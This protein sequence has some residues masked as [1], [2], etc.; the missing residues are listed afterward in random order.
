MM[1]QAAGLPTVFFT[2]TLRQICHGSYTS[3]NRV[4]IDRCPTFASTSQTMKSPND[5]GNVISVI[6]T[7][8]V[9]VGNPDE[10][11]LPLLKRHPQL[12]L[13]GDGKLPGLLNIMSNFKVNTTCP[14]LLANRSSY[15]ILRSFQS[16]LC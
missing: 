8:Q 6:E 10:K 13:N 7:S 15:V 3:S 2:F 5:I 4:E 1:P 14:L 9:C 12:L 16:R 11:F